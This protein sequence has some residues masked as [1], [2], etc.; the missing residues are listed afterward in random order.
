MQYI[1]WPHTETSTSEMFGGGY[2]WKIGSDLVLLGLL[3][4]SAS[5]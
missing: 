5:Q 2:Y 3:F 1:R 4:L